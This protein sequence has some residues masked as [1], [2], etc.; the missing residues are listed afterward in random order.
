MIWDL[1]FGGIAKTLRS[2]AET[3]VNMF[4]TFDIPDWRGSIGL[5]I[6]EHAQPLSVF[7]G[8]VDFAAVESALQFVVAAW[9][10]S[11]ALRMARVILSL[12]TGGGGS[13]T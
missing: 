6:N 5:W 7:R 2:L 3:V 4:P 10:T 12:F 13:A 8:F 11:T 1:L 9:L